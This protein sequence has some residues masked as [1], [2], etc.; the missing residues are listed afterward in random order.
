MGT[1]TNY[2][3][4]YP[5]GSE[6]PNG[7]YSFQ[8]LADALDTELKARHDRRTKHYPTGGPGGPVLLGGEAAWKDLAT[9]NAT[10]RGQV[11]SVEFHAN[12]SNQN[13]GLHRIT[14]WRLLVGS[15]VLWTGQADAPYRGGD[16]PHYTISFQKDTTPS[17]GA[18]VFKL[19]AYATIANAVEVSD[20]VLS[21]TEWEA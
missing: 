5:G 15:T 16:T 10:V 17:A 11:C 4:P 14:V 12:Y 9:V 21:V 8:Q 19:Q 2:D 7:P 3:F 1:T 6:G 13:S 18:K 20:A